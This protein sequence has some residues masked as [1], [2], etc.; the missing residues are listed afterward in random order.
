MKEF[1]SPINFG[2]QPSY[3]VKQRKKYSSIWMLYT[4]TEILKLKF[5]EDQA[6]TAQLKRLPRILKLNFF[7]P[8][9]QEKETYSR[10]I[11][12]N[13][14]QLFVSYCCCSRTV[15]PAFLQLSSQ[16]RSFLAPLEAREGKM[17]HVLQMV[18]VR[19]IVNP[20]VRYQCTDYRQAALTPGRIRKQ[21]S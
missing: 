9:C 10:N 2:T 16:K 4:T 13:K 19:L 14:V 7:Q 8:V 12:I 11:R 17:H 20:M 21:K 18:K 6:F 1:C 5:S 3:P 15:N